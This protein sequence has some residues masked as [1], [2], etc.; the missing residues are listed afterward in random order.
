SLQGGEGDLAVHLFVV[1]LEG[2][3]DEALLR[4]REAAAG[5]EAYE[6]LLRLNLD[7]EVGTG[8]QLLLRRG[9][10]DPGDLAIAV[11]DLGDDYWIDLRMLTSGPGG[12]REE[13]WSEL[14]DSLRARREAPVDA[15][16]V[17]DA[18]EEDEEPYFTAAARELLE[19]S[20]FLAESTWAKVV[21]AQGDGTLLIR[22]AK[23]VV[24]TNPGTGAEPSES[25]P[26]ELEI[27]LSS[28][29]Y[30]SG[31]PV[32][33]GSEVLYLESGKEVQRIVDGE[34]E[35][36]G[37]TADRATAAGEELLLARSPEARSLLGFD[38]LPA[39]GPTRLLLRK[40][41]GSERT[42]AEIAERSVEALAYQDGLALVAAVPRAAPGA[43]QDEAERELLLIDL[44]TGT[45]R[46]LER[47]KSVER[48]APAA[49]R[50]L[51][52]GTLGGGEEGVFLVAAEGG[53][54]LVLS[55]GQVGLGGDEE[56][57][58]FA[59]ERCLGEGAAVGCVYRAPLPKV[60][61]LGRE[62]WPFGVHLLNEAAAEISER[63][64]SAVVPSDPRTLDEVRALTAL[65]DEV[66]SARAGAPLPAAA[67]GIDLLVGQ[68]VYEE[69][70][71]NEAI[72]LLSALVTK[73][74]LAEGA[75]WVAPE[76]AVPPRLGASGWEAENAFAVGLR[77]VAVVQSTL[78]DGESW[79]QP[80]DEILE[81]SRGRRIFVGPDAA[82]LRAAV[83]GADQA[84]LSELIREASRD[85]LV[86]LLEEDPG[87][88]YLR[89]EVYRGLAARG[90][91][92]VL[93]SVA[94]S[95]AASEGAAGIDRIAAAAG[96]LAGD[97]SP[98]EADELLVGL[99]ASIEESP[100]EAALYL[101]LGAAYE[102]SS[103]PEKLKYARVCF[104]KVGELGV[105]GPVAEAAEA[106]LERLA[107][108][109]E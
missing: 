8:E 90:R 79:Y 78:F 30:L 98:D 45:V 72:A 81:R 88:L 102:R 59:A 2:G 84:D 26:A 16:P 71:S 29:S 17:V 54:E 67:A 31:T 9:G 73:A 35:A 75:Q 105:Y 19:A 6:E 91:H 22:E 104:E 48:V 100:G 61:E 97:P 66:V 32:G 101:L 24:R 3:A 36:A 43:G 89:D 38:H 99:R 50:W 34:L 93:T 92:E 68:L 56:S 28:G 5:D 37:F 39:V 53:R 63:Q 1:E 76:A 23:R 13:L 18:A 25:G 85:R 55:G 58:L 10:D 69:E 4:I 40:R 103:L 46:E 94:E 27:L 44:A 109:G 51:V 11:I 87:N 52:S 7:L 74:F 49:G 80:V 12:H 82:S 47:W 70:V 95:F 65:A 77:P 108:A 21:E 15:F 20:R 106:A 42:V 86:A 62:F 83:P 14:L 41:D 107:S 60:R 33:W 64:R 96:R 57:L